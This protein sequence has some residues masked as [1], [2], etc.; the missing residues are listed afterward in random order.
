MFHNKEQELLTLVKEKADYLVNKINSINSKELSSVKMYIALNLWLWFDD[1]LF[2]DKSNDPVDSL[3]NLLSNHLSLIEILEKNKIYI[4]NNFKDESTFQEN[5][6]NTF[7]DIWLQYSLPDYFIRT[8]EDTKNRYL[9]NMVNPFEFYSNKYVLDAGCGSGKVTSSIARFGA[10]KV[11]G[12][13][14]TKDGINFKK[15]IKEFPEG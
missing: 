14:L 8:F 2:S 15:K 11:I 6:G 9:V 4:T 7:K 12:I 3:L 10:R 13:D 5:I 1:E